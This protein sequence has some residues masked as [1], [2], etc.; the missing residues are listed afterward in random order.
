MTQ[1][2]DA[3]PAGS[4]TGVPSNSDAGI[5]AAI[6]RG[7]RA[8]IARAISRIE[9][10]DAGMDAVLEQ[11]AAGG[12]ASR[13]IGITGPPGAGKSTLCLQLVREFRRAGA[14]VAVLAVDPSSPF[15]GGA[16]LGD[17]VRMNDVAGDEQVFVRSFATR[18]AL[19]GLSAAVAD[20]AEL[21]DA[22]GFDYLLIETVGVG[23]SECDIVRLCDCVLVVLTPESGDEIQVAKAGLMEIADVFV[24]NKNDRPGGDRLRAALRAMLDL[25]TAR[26]A[27][28]GCRPPI[29]STVAEEGG[30][31]PELAAAIR[32]H[33]EQ[34]Q[35]S[36]AQAQ[37]QR[38]RRRQRVLQWLPRLIDRE[39][40]SPSR[41][42]LLDRA[43]EERSGGSV[44]AIARRLV[45]DF[46]ASD[47]RHR[48]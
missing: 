33:D 35:R 26:R 43:L 25:D 38:E 19:G 31:V 4:D 3:D 23:Q 7:E 21:F 48:P 28:R 18:G 11:L 45:D 36:G 6:R 29:V 8:A 46:L 15:T 2:S 12:G 39:L 47:T 40:W 27:A 24:I 17:R 34:Q 30:G 14:R 44:L 32:E 16:L 5:A 10:R 13:R 42:A 41:L 22:A 9:R 37:R 1:R 20:A